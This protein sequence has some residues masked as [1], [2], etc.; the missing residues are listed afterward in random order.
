VYAEDADAILAWLRSL[1]PVE[2][3]HAGHRLRGL[4][5]SPLALSAWRAMWFRPLVHQEDPGR[6]A[7]WN[8]GAYLVRGLAHCSAC[9]APRNR[10]GAIDREREFDGAPMISARWYAPSL[11]DPGEA[12]SRGLPAADVVALLRDGVAPHGSALGPMAEV[13]LHGTTYLSDSDLEAMVA[14]LSD[15]PVSRARAAVSRARPRPAEPRVLE[16]G[17]RLYR[18]HCQ[19]CHGPEGEGTEGI[20]GLAGNRALTS[21]SAANVIRVVLAGGF[22]PA[23]AG[24]PRPWGMPPF[25]HRLSNEEAAAVVSYVRQAWGNGAAGVDSGEVARW[26]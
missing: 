12:G 24:N 14:F 20:R 26:R 18:E 16:A 2:A 10:W 3:P 25:S 11:L 13:V 4:A 17:A 9:H 15:P 22:P 5:G 6:S 21:A 1:P 8:R 19:D 23:T 7:A